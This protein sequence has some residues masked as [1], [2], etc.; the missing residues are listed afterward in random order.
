M[1]HIRQDDKT[2]IFERLINSRGKKVKNETFGYWW[3]AFYLGSFLTNLYFHSGII[4]PWFNL[5]IS[6]LVIWSNSLS[7][8]KRNG[9]TK[10]LSSTF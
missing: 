6:T 4:D 7:Y 8:P 5:F 10:V 2:F 3:V 9:S 1:K